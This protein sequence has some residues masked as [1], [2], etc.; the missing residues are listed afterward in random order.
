VQSKLDKLFNAPTKSKCSDKY[1]I[2]NKSKSKGDK[3]K[4]IETSAKS[5]TPVKI[6]EKPRV[7]LSSLK[8]SK[9]IMSNGGN[10]TTP[11]NVNSLTDL[12]EEYNGLSY[13]SAKVMTPRKQGVEEKVEPVKKKSIEKDFRIKY[14]TE[15]CKFFEN[16]KECKFG[17]NVINN[18]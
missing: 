1:L 6:P 2:F 16:S 12:N 9:N 4:L 7:D 5:K 11:I 8:I 13:K 14:K 10:I 17:D 15:K 18:L 3:I